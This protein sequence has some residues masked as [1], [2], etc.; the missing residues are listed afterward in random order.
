MAYIHKYITNDGE[1]L[2]SNVVPKFRHKKIQKIL[3]KLHKILTRIQK[4]DATQV[5][6]NEGIVKKMHNSSR[7]SRTF[8]QGRR[9]I[10]KYK[11]NE[12]LIMRYKNCTPIY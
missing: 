11:T 3:Y 10:Y 9:N 1:I 8:F 5:R 12:G 2:L 7:V 4:E 6:T